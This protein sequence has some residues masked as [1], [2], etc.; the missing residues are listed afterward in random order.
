MAIE[1]TNMQDGSQL[2]FEDSSFTIVPTGLSQD[3][4]RTVRNASK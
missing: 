1:D 3:R 2:L 4:M